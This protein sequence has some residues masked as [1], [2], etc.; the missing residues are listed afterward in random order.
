MKTPRPDVLFFDLNETLIDLKEV[1]AS[2]T[3]A[4]GDEK[5]VASVWF[6]TLLHYS[7][8]AT[9]SQQYHNFGQIGAAALVMVA[10][11]RG[12][13]MSM[14]R[15]RQILAPV[16]TAPAH[17]EV[18]AALQRLKRE[19]FRMAT[20]TNSSRAAMKAQLENAGIDSYF[21]QTLSVEDVAIYKPHRHVYLWAARRMNVAPQECM[22][23]A[24]HG[25]DMAGA[26]AA[27]ME[28]AFISRPGQSL[29]P[30]SPAPAYT[31]PDLEKFV[32]QLVGQ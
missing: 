9:V 17:P 8:V 14:E 26:K 21:E 3:S 13:E 30:L 2:I 16:R 5:N 32:Q 28:T 22:L 1:R 25:W 31:E 19:G 23:I 12:I 20:L 4:L 10:Q 18:P 11:N 6:E 29:Y 24:A 7:L 15:A 27:G